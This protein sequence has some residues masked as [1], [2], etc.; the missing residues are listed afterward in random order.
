MLGVIT[1]LVTG[2]SGTTIDV[3]AMGTLVIDTLSRMRERLE[4]TS[5]GN[6]DMFYLNK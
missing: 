1:A 5:L 3:V 6:L 2:K 4:A